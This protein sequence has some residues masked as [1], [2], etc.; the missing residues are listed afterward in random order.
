MK[1]LVCH[2][3]H[4]III[5]KYRFKILATVKNL[6][7]WRVAGSQQRKEKKYVCQL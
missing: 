1:M 6:I 5:K 2:C 3:R 4:V 7:I